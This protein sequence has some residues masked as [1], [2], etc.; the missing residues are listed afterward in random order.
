MKVSEKIV[1][2]TQ[3]FFYVSVVLMLLQQWQ[4]L[5]LLRKMGDYLVLII[6]ILSILLFNQ[7]QRKLNIIERVAIFLIGIFL[8]RITFLHNLF[9]D[10][11][12]AFPV[13]GEYSNII[14]SIQFVVVFILLII[15]K[16]KILKLYI[17][18][19]AIY[20]SCVS[21]FFGLLLILLR[22]IFSKIMLPF[23]QYG[24]KLIFPFDPF[25][26]YHSS[27]VIFIIIM[28]LAFGVP[29][30]INK[31]LDKSNAFKS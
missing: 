17:N 9:Y 10:R 26:L 31:I 30:L 20:F 18:K 12:E 7:S 5:V 13:F 24:T 22:G 8:F 14:L 19:K 15:Y 6:Y 4:M 28:P 21:F 27:I 16:G 3:Y 2:Y 29:M 25:L 11:K 23:F 1:L